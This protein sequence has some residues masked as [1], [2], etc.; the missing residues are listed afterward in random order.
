M[1]HADHTCVRV[2][3]FTVESGTTTGRA[4]TDEHTCKT[5]AFT[6][7]C[8]LFDRNPRSGGAKV[9]NEREGSNS[10]VK[11]VPELVIGQFDDHLEGPLHRAVRRVDARP[12]GVLEHLAWLEHRLVP[13]NPRTA[14][15]HVSHH[16]A[17][18]I[19]Y[20]P[21]TREKLHRIL[22][23]V[24]DPYPVREE[25]LAC[26]RIGLLREVLTRDLDLDASRDGDRG[27]F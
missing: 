22:A 16:L 13:H 4:E 5:H 14:S 27:A 17:I 18:T 10:G 7:S 26:G 2:I 15:R 25:P 9:G 6:H 1:R 23:L 8:S 24:L 19:E 12:A 21:L 11:L 20:V 3:H